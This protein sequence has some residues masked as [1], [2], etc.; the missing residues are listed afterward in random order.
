VLGFQLPARPALRCLEQRSVGADP[1]PAA[2]YSAQRLQR[3]PALRSQQDARRD[4]G[5]LA[6]RRRPPR[7][8]QRSNRHG[9]LRRLLVGLP[10]SAIQRAPGKK[11]AESVGSICS[12]PAINASGEL[13]DNARPCR[14]R[15]D[16]SAS[17]QSGRR[18]TP[19]LK[20]RGT[21]TSA[22]VARPTFPSTTRRPT[23]TSAGS[24]S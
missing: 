24:A 15:A 16:V 21:T 18:R 12:I 20:A 13:D 2:D 6:R 11:P 5:A 17:A 3:S 9:L 23:Q 4:D 1:L 19:I 7:P 22:R 10:S 14:R 8:D